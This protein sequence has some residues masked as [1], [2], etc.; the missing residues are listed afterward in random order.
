MSVNDAERDGSSTNIATI[1]PVSGGNTAELQP[2]VASPWHSDQR[3]TIPDPV[4]GHIERKALAERCA[5]ANRRLTV[6]KAPGGFGKTTLLAASCRDLLDRGVPVAWLSL[7]GEDEPG[8]LDMHIAHA[9]QRAGLDVFDQRPNGAEP[10]PRSDPVTELLEALEN[11]EGPW[12]L[13]LD[14]LQTLTGRASVA[15]L[16]ELVRNA[17]PT[18]HLAVSCRE[19]PVGLDLAG[20]LFEGAADFLTEED[21]R[22][23]R[24]E[25]ERLFD[26]KLSRRELAAVAASSAGWPIA[27]G[28]ERAARAGQARERDVQDLMY[29]WV[30]S[31]LWSD[32]AEDEGE[33]LLDVGLFETID[34]EL[35]EEV[36]GGRDLVGKL[37]GMSGVAGLLEPVRGSGG[38][39]LRLHPLVRGHC[40]NRRRREAPERF[41]HVHRSLATALARRGETGDAVE[42]AA[43]ADDPALVGRILTDGGGVRIW[44]REGEERLLDVSRYLTDETIALFPRLALIRGV[45]QIFRGWLPQARRTLD[46]AARELLAAGSAPAATAGTGASDAAPSGADAV[47]PKVGGAPPKVSGGPEIERC[48]ALG[49]LALNGCAPVGSSLFKAVIAHCERIV[50]Q[51]GIEPLVR[52]TVEWGICE[53]HN[54]K[55]EFEQALDRGTRT[56]RWL[57]GRS[58]YLSLATDGI[59]GQVAMA[60]GHSGQ[61]ADWYEKSIRAAR[62]KF[63]DNP[64]MEVF[65]A[66]L[67]RELDLERNRMESADDGVAGLREIW[68]G[69]SSLPFYAAATTVAVELTLHKLGVE[70]ALSMADEMWEQ[71]VQAELPAVARYLAG[72]GVA[73]LAVAGRTGEAE[74]RWQ[75]ESLPDSHAGCLDLAGQSWREMEVMSCARLRLAAARGEFD[76][77]REL[78]RELLDLTGRRGLRRTL[79][80]ALVLGIALEEAAGDRKAALGHLET[81]LDLYA[82]T[83]YGW[84]VVRER[85]VTVPVLEAFRDGNPGSPLGA[86]AEALLEASSTS[87]S[88]VAPLLSAREAEVLARL[89]QQTDRAIGEE[90]G[91]SAQGVRYYI[92]KLFAK[93]EVRNRYDGVQRA[94]SLGLLP[95]D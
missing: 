30:E 17:P 28:I 75:L 76:E 25:I 73:V 18:L 53:A 52:A 79:M 71:A 55:A 94:R 11:R 10:P 16:N 85:R 54:Q 3:V 12:V 43:E 8:A 37:K 89:E 60:Q 95:P 15:S 5:P 38:K 2:G 31:S 63:P 88:Q 40:A 56:R 59:F 69:S 6:L 34:A 84:A 24:A 44:P 61:A 47:P 21:L 35:V 46:A 93:L 42:H 70:S 57:G 90:L 82:E 39:V 9:F 33:F 86:S 58:S 92:R 19:F 32:L 7:D 41:R 1:G 66:A 14:N 80:R 50:E 64:R 62:R 67:K 83:D 23:S 45:A 51:P 65:N 22:F 77:G 81:F 20:P 13:A 78:L 49:M 27:L 29:N 4:A 68:G 87:P 36:L 91:M 48:I 72:M 26:G 74:Q